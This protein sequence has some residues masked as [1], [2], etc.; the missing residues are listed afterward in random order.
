MSPES[1]PTSEIAARLAD[2][3][4]FLEPG[5]VLF[6]ETPDLGDNL[7]APLHGVDPA[8]CPV[9][10]LFSGPGADALSAQVMG[11]VT[12]L[13]S[14]PD[15]FRIWYSSAERPRFFLVATDWTLGELERLVVLRE[16][17]S[18]QVF[19]VRR[20]GPTGFRLRRE[21]LGED[22]EDPAKA[23]E[24]VQGT[25]LKRLLNAST[26]IN[27][28]LSVS[29]LSWPLVLNGGEGPLASIHNFDGELI[30]AV[31][32]REGPRL[33]E[34]VDEDAVDEAIDILLRGHWAGVA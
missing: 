25:L 5:L 10:V 21:K 22:G 20:D 4:D 14:D 28:P 3:P 16:A 27:P 23:L 9:F 31:S 30:F 8:G 34:I 2:R 11:I 1:S 13:K 24:T 26:C 12:A 18:I 19:S 32:G 15:A 6:P 7:H 33:I 29:A 17:V